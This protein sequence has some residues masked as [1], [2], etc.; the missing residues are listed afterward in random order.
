MGVFVGCVQRAHGDLVAWIPATLC[1][2]PNGSCTHA[3]AAPDSVGPDG[4]TIPGGRDERLTLFLVQLRHPTSKAL[5]NMEV[6]KRERMSS[7]TFINATI[8]NPV[9]HLL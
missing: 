5:Q 3:S 8:S 4:A 6:S 1:L 9:I 7:G 2:Y